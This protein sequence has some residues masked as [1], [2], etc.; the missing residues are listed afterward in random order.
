MAIGPSARPASSSRTNTIT[1]PDAIAAPNVWVETTEPWTVTP[2]PEPSRPSSPKLISSLIAQYTPS[3]AR[4]ATAALSPSAT[5]VGQ[6][7]P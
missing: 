5:S 7:R 6:C 4:T 2:P 3:M 1:A